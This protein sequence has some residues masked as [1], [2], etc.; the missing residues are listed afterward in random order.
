ML[1]FNVVFQ[2]TDC[3]F[4][5]RLSNTSEKIM[6][7][8]GAVFEVENKHRDIYDGSYTVTPKAHDKTV[9]NTANKILLE[10]VTVVEI[11]YYETT[12]PYGSTIFIA[13]EV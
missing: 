12:N 4:N 9:L 1:N 7:D 3:D 11:P 10:D 6:V 8:M 5:A 2:S 13:N